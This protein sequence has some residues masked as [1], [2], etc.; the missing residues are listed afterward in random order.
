MGKRSKDKDRGEDG[1]AGDASSPTRKKMKKHK[2]KHKKQKKQR[3]EVS[4]EEIDV[5]NNT[6]V[7]PCS[8]QDEGKGLKLKIKFGGKT[9][10]EVVTTSSVNNS[11]V[12]VEEED[13]DDVSW[14]AEN[15]AIQKQTA[16]TTT[17][18]NNTKGSHGK[19]EEEEDRWLEALE[20]GELD[21]TGDVKKKK[22]LNPAMMTSRQRALHGEA[23]VGE[24]E[25]LELPMYPEKSEVES[26]EVERKRKLK[27]KK[28]KQLEEKQ[29][30]E[31]KALTIEK[32]LTKG[33][34]QKT[35]KDVL[36]VKTDKNKTGEGYYRYSDSA[37]GVFI[38]YPEGLTFPLAPVVA[39]EPPKPVVCSV[40][41]CVNV[42]K[43]ACSRTKLPV[44]SLQCYKLLT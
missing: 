25:L 7:T 1:C 42:K 28:R 39:K 30:E 34:S 8:S 13:E 14:S 44:C 37:L 32:L 33:G 31:T 19:S 17:T 26:E 3:H 27:A 2:H 16:T 12:E 22:E 5:V 21:E 41:G 35:K 15:T 38:A 20:K 11:D 40:D 23:V 24:N 9:L 29:A 43:Y 18:D 4:D 10:T 6:D 36:N